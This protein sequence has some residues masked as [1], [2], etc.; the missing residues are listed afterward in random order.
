[1]TGRWT[2]KGI[3][4]SN[5]KTIDSRIIFAPDLEG[6]WLSVRHDDLPPN[7]FHAA[8]FWGTDGTSK[9][10]V[11]FMYDNFGGSRKFTSPGWNSNKLIW[12]RETAESSPPATE[13]FVYQLDNPNQLVVNWEA[14]HGAADWTIGDTLTCHPES[15]TMAH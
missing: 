15:T 7:H 4:P 3:F 1:M 9:L 10:F 8:E 6:A 11:A 5:G 2:C 14:K 12:T 13:R